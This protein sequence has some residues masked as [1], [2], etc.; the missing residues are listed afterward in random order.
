MAIKEIVV[1]YE[2]FEN[3]LKLPTKINS[4]VIPHFSSA[5][6][7]W[8]SKRRYYPVLIDFSGVA[9]PYANGMLPIISIISKLRLDGYDIKIRLPNDKKVRDIFIKNKLGLLFRE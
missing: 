4:F 1:R 3:T 8:K 9:Y 6:N 5:I 7:L 2:Q